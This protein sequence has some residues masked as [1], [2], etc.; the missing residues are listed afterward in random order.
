MFILVKTLQHWSKPKNTFTHFLGLIYTFLCTR[1]SKFVYFLH[2][3]VEAYFGWDL[4]FGFACT[5]K[6]VN[7][8]QKVCKCVF[9]FAPLR[10]VFRIL[11]ADVFIYYITVNV[12]T[13]KRECLLSKAYNFYFRTSTKYF[14][15]TFFVGESKSKLPL[16][17][18]LT[19][20]FAHIGITVYPGS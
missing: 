5:Q 10:G 2:K 16:L 8:S 14:A 9:G 6:C 17:E 13:I 15:K 11:C 19:Y 12:H 7:E 18:A 3:S 4:K 20:H 1:K